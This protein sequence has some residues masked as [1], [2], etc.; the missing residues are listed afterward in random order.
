MAST[1]SP[2]LT[3]S[4]FWPGGSAEKPIRDQPKA[5]PQSNC[6]RSAGGSPPSREPIYADFPVIFCAGDDACGREI[7][8]SARCCP[9]QVRKNANQITPRIK[10][11][12]PVETTSRASTDGP[13]SACRASVG[14]SM[15][16]RC[17][18]A[19]MGPSISFCHAR[20]RPLIR[21]WVPRATH[22]F[23]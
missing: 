19:A 8:V 15:I 7:F 9:S 16:W 2:L 13:G 6:S 11:A 20:G 21:R 5:R 1:Q 23:R 3:R 10:T 12:R 4:V 22:D 17:C 14:V 18:R